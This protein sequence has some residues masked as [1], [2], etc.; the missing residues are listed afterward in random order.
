MRTKPAP[1]TRPD[2]DAAA[3]ATPARSARAAA[4]TELSPVSSWIAMPWSVRVLRAFLGITF[5]FAGAQ[6]LLDG[7]YLH[8]GSPDFIGTQLSGFAHGTPVSAI[9]ALLEKAPVTVGVAVALTEIAVGIATLLG[10]G[11]LTVAAV[12]FVINFT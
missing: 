9:M 4:G 12:G 2:M 6:K 8:V 11:M 1:P 3:P 5:V 7:R 10:I